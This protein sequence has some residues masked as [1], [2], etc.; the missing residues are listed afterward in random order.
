MERI[1]YQEVPAEIF[2]KVVAL[3]NEKDLLDSKINNGN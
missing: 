1:S 2:D 3:K